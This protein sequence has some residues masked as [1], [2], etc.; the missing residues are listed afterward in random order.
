MTRL[1]VAHQCLLCRFDNS[2]AKSAVFILLGVS[3]LIRLCLDTMPDAR[4]KNYEEPY[5]NNTY[6]TPQTDLVIETWHHE[7]Q[8]AGHQLPRN[9]E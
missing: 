4:S 8:G 7:L 1:D 2:I 6:P 5:S 9:A 3:I